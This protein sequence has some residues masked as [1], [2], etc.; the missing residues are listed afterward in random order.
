MT[1]DRGGHSGP[2]Q[3]E[4]QSTDQTWA[5]LRTPLLGFLFVLTAILVG[6]Q[7]PLLNQTL[8]LGAGVAGVI[9]AGAAVATRIKQMFAKE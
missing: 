9:G 5:R 4:T 3:W 7:Q 2:R 6:T 8:S 1:R